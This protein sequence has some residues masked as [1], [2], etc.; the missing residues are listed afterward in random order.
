MGPSANFGMHRRLLICLLAFCISAAWIPIVQAASV[1][2]SRTTAKS[3]VGTPVDLI[4]PGDYL[5]SDFTV[6]NGLPNNVVNAIV[7]TQNGLLWVG[8]DSG[9]ASFDGRDFTSINLETEG[10]PP[11]GGVHSL[12]ESSSGDLWVGTNAGVVRIPKT[13]LDQFSSSLL[14]FYRLGSGPNSEVDDLFQDRE[15]VLWAGSTHGLYRQ[16]SSTFVATI[17]DLSISHISQKIDG[18]LLLINDGKLI[19]WDGQRI[20]V[21]SDLAR[22]LGIP[23]SEIFHAFQNNDGTIW[24]STQK[25]I[26]RQGQ[27]PMPRLRPLV[28]SE[29]SALRTYK[30]TEGN[31]WVV[32]GTGVYRVNG[33]VM[34]DTPVPNTLPVSF[35]A[36]REGG[37]WIGTNGNGLI[38]LV[39]RTVHVFTTAD[40]LLS[41]I[42]MTVLPTHDGRIWLGSNCGL[43]MYDGHRFESYKEKDGLL[44]SCV[45]TLAEDHNRTLWIGTYGG[46][47]FRFR[48]GRFVQYSLPQGLPSKVVLQVIVAGDGS[49]WIATLDGVSHMQNDHFR[50]YTIADGLSSNQVITIHQDRSGTIWAATQ[51]GL[52]RL[53]GQRFIQFP[54]ARSNDSPFPIRIA[55]DSVGDLFTADSPRGIS[56]ITDNELVKLNHDF[57]VLDMVEAPDHVIWA[58]GTNGILRFRV[59][60]LKNSL[61][62]REAPLDYELI[63]RS[64]GLSSIQCSIGSPNLAITPDN[65]LWVATVKGLAMLDLSSLPGAGRKPKLFIGAV[66]AGKDRLLAR[67]ETVLPPGTNHVELHLQAVDL[68]SPEKIRLQYRLDGVDAGWL[69]ASTSRTAVYTNIPNGT[70]TFHVRATSSDGVWDRDGVTYS[71]T[72]RPYFY[73]TTWFLSLCLVGL[74]LLTW[75]ASQWRVRQAQARV[76]LQ[77]EERLSER[78][79]IARDL[80]DTLLQSFQGLILTFQRARNLLPGRPD[81]AMVQLDTALDR[82][83]SAIM[84]G[85]DAIHDIRASASHDRD[86]TDVISGLGEELASENEQFGFP[87]FRVVVEGGPKEIN[88]IVRDEI[89]RITREALRNAF[90]HAHARKIEAEVRYEEKV[91]RLRIRDDGVGINETHLGETGRSGHYGLRGMRERATRIGAQLEVWSERGAGA[92]IELRVPDAVAYLT[93]GQDN[94]A[95][96]RDARVNVKES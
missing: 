26:F 36:D 13:A 91:L 28:A 30:D 8:T 61:S 78:A 66:T 39:R 60:D 44:N 69:D 41:N 67:S 14:T 34:E 40:G 59:N 82:A 51:G 93:R 88:P 92:E 23:G 77:M 73:Q 33:D 85:R 55:E 56:L 6:E 4:N 12:L 7:Q 74:M 50:N 90:V 10:A 71:I 27:K 63:D 18:H 22:S 21:H 54:R 37:F 57:K 94:V 11:P 20:D 49:L 25:G 15:G 96:G 70:H 5:R 3:S 65:K 46:G 42:A 19:E 80:H 83:E 89:Y 72:Q 64:D 16:Q 76:H 24:Y 32:S 62:D 53:V 47:L 38:H 79:R 87:S 58:S 45:W 48:N 2:S 68:E 17:P 52:D 95:T 75:Q 9:L 84:E 29:T 1:N 43:S 31:V 35:Q 81:Q 86:L